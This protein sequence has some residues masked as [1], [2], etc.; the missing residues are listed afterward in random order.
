MAIVFVFGIYLL[1][2]SLFFTSLYNWDQFSLSE[3]HN[4]KCLLLTQKK[5]K[6]KKHNAPVIEIKANQ[7][8]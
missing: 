2:L 1:P 4:W 6:N 3:K 8:E 5:Q 7:Q